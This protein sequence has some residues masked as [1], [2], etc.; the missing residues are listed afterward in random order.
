MQSMSG[1]PRVFHKAGGEPVTEADRLANEIILRGLEERFPSDRVLSEE[2]SDDLSRLEHRRVWIVDPI[3]G[4]Q[5]LI[6]GTGQFT[7]MIG[8]AV[9]GEPVIGALYQP[10]GGRLWHAEVGVDAVLAEGKQAGHPIGVSVRGVSDGIRLVL[11]R[12]HRFPGWQELMRVS[13][14]ESARTIGSIGLKVAAIAEG[15]AELYVHISRITKEWDTCAPDAI[16][17]AAGGCL[18]DLAGA[19]ILYNKRNTRNQRGI[20]ASNGLVHEWA[21][22]KADPFARQAGLLDDG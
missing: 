1:K 6:N 20:L 7:V 5:E 17:R 9:A 11:T 19:P 16:L 2:S 22:Q 8:L 4:T 10:V 13:G 14:I 12:T 18:T 3:D 15:A 21:R